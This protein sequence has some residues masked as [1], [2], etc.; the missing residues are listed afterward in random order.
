MAGRGKQIIVTNNPRGVFIEGRINAG[1]SPKP[2]TIV[3][4]DPTQAMVGG[5]F[6]LKIYATGTD[7]KKPKGPY[8]VLLEDNLRGR[9]IDDAYAAGDWC[10]GY[11]P[12]QGEE[13]NLL[14]KNVAGT[15]DD[16]LKGDQLIVDDATGKMIVTTGS[17]ETIPAMSLEAIT[18]PT[19]DTL[20]W[21]IWSGY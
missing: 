15:A 10:R 20:V 21:S 17:P 13:M 3:Q 1:E 7:G 6:V 12:I 5:R 16:V 14:Y 8:I 19:A 11:V 2:G 4:I 18:D 9:T